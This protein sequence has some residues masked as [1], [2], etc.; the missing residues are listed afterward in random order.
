MTSIRQ[1]PLAALL[2]WLGACSAET[3][4]ATPPPFAPTLGPW[5]AQFG[6]T[7]E[8]DC[9][10]ED[11]QTHEAPTQLWQVDD[12]YRYGFSVMDEEGYW[13]GCTLEATAFVCA[14]PI[15]AD[16]FTSLGYDVHATYTPTWEGEFTDSSA[17][18]GVYRLEAECEGE[19]CDL[20]DGYGKRFE[21]PC[22]VETPIVAS[23]MD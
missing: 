19:D 1:V 15:I 7:W 14:L 8:G 6:A 12:D 5:S 16:D 18:A 22:A 17:L 20:L 23:A 4:T 13:Y 21:F 11:P 3:D 2:A 9:A 10:L